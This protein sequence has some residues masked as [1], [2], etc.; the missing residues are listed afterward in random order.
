MTALKTQNRFVFEFLFSVLNTRNRIHSAGHTAHSIR[1]PLT[2]TELTSERFLHSTGIIQ[3]HTKKKRSETKYEGDVWR[4]CKADGA[5][6]RKSTPFVSSCRDQRLDWCVISAGHTAKRK[7]L[8][9]KASDVVWL[10]KVVIH[11]LWRG[12][13]VKQVEQNTGDV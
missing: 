2:R 11:D 10:L 9:I 8:T 1:V 7:A 6:H 12:D 4:W 13:G 5:E 3:G